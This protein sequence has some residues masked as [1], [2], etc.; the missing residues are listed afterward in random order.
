MKPDLTNTLCTGCGLCCDGSFFADVELTDRDEA[1]ALE[2]MGLDIEDDDD[3]GSLLLQPCRALKGKL[4]GIYPFRPKCCRAFE[5]R[6]LRDV[7]RGRVSNDQ[8]KEKV[9]EALLGVA[10]VKELLVLLGQSNDERL[11]LKERCAEALA[12]SEEV[13]PDPARNRRR[14]ELETAMAIVQNLLHETFLAGGNWRR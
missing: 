5:C 4:C 10:R 6:L 12:V 13:D 3:D 8:A 14:A 11:P 2:V 7:K 9:A 1:S